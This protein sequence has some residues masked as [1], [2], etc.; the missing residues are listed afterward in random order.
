MTLPT[1]PQRDAATPALPRATQTL[2]ARLDGWVHTIE[3]AH[4]PCEF[5]GLSETTD[6]DGKRS[7]IT[8]TEQVDSIC[9][10]GDHH[11]GRA[12]V[13]LWI[14]RPSGK[15]WTLETA[16]RGA[17]PWEP[18]PK[19]LTATELTAYVVDPPPV[20]PR[21]AEQLE[22]DLAE[23]AEHRARWEANQDVW[24]PIPQRWSTVQP[25]A[26][27]IAPNGHPWH[28][29]WVAST[30]SR[31]GYRITRGEAEHSAVVAPDAPVQVLVP[32]PERD[33]LTLSRAVLGS[34]IIERRTA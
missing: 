30:A 25:G 20:D 14:R 23:L 19:Q 8:I 9:V 15:G 24:V 34:R 28:V 4:G 31:T 22:R 12:F 17:W 29:E 3:H 13:A 21:V 10:R 27:V 7:R 2:I 16:W 6:G 5:G 32:V 33:A 1:A 26:V 18:A 11:E